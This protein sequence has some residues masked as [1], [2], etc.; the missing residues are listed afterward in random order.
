MEPQAWEWDGQWE[1]PLEVIE[2]RLDKVRGELDAGLAERNRRKR[3]RQ[4]ALDRALA[5]RRRM[6]H[7]RSHLPQRRA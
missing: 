6:R 4:S 7:G 2:R 5:K 3:N 1:T